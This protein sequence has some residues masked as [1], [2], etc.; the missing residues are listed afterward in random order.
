M[1]IVPTERWHSSAIRCFLLEPELVTDVYVGWLNDPQINRFLESRFVVQDLSGVR[2]FVAVQ[3]ADARTLFLGIRS[4]A[5]DRHVGNIKLGPIDWHHG[6]GEIGIM[7]GDRGAWGQGVGTEAIRLLADIARHE[8][9]LRKLTA[10]CYAS[11][12]ASARAFEKAGFS[13]E[14]VRRA[15]FLLDG[16]PEDL[17]LMARHLPPIVA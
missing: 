5:L 16:K 10:G 8:L 15:H 2:E 1:R 4:A 7:I 11:N 17:I 9:G 13:R 6:L 12:A 3:L 14:G